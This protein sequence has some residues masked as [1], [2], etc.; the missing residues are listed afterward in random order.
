[1]EAHLSE[2][3]QAIEAELYPELEHQPSESDRLAIRAALAKAAAG[4]HQL[5]TATLAERV[6]AALAE[7]ELEAG[8]SEAPELGARP[9]QVAESGSADPDPAEP[10]DPR[11]E[12]LTDVWGNPI[13]PRRRRRP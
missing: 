5:G 6:R 4:G 9:E 12:R 11:R 10:S 2:L 8:A 13:R 3:L 7:G 1:M